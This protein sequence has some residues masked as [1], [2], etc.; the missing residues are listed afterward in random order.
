[1]E[2]KSEEI[3]KP[4]S[5]F[6][7]LVQMLITI[8]NVIKNY[9][10]APSSKGICSDVAARSVM[11]DVIIAV[12]P[13]AFYGIVIFGWRAAVIIAISVV[14]AVACEFIWNKALKKQNTLGDLTA[15]VTG[16][17]L[18]LS[19]PTTLPFPMRYCL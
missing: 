13:A 7:K 6:S 1:M 18:A 10:F 4:V 17:L 12:L 3:L 5:R 15:I 11:L 2:N 9:L 14:S 8:K 19:L 16:L